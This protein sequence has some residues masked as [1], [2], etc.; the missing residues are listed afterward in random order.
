M[1]AHLV[2][3]S[4]TVHDLPFQRIFDHE[5]AWDRELQEGTV[6]ALTDGTLGWGTRAG[7][8][9]KPRPNDLIRTEGGSLPREFLAACLEN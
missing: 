2:A 7:P 5:L 4:G 9:H 6:P 8:Q 1:P 3:A